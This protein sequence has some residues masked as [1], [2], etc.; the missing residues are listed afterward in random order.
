MSNPFKVFRKH[1]KK[2]IAALGVLCMVAFTILPVVMQMFD[3][4]G[5]SPSSTVVTTRY[6]E[7]SEGLLGQLLSQRRFV[8]SF[9]FQAMLPTLPDV[10]QFEVAQRDQARYFYQVMLDRDI[11]GMFGSDTEEDV[12]DGWLMSREAERMGIDFSDAAVT[13]FIR[14]QTQNRVDGATLDNLVRS[15]GGT[16]AMLY[17]ALRRELMAHAARD[18]LQ[19]SSRLTPAERWEYYRRLNAQATIEV[20]P[21]RVEDFVSQVPEPSGDVVETF[22]DEHKDDLPVPGSP[23]PGFKKPKECV[24]QFFQAALEP[25][26]DEADVTEK[27]IADHYEQFKEFRY[28]YTGFSEDSTT[29]S[30][31]TSSEETS[32]EG[33]ETSESA[34]ESPESSSSAPSDA[35]P[36]SDTPPS[37]SEPPAE[38]EGGPALQSPGEGTTEPPDEGSTSAVRSR[39][40]ELATTEDTFQFVSYLQESNEPATT[41]ESAVAD[42]TPTSDPDATATDDS[43]TGE[44]ETG[45]SP[46]AD[47][48]EANVEPSVVLPPAPPL[49]EPFEMPRD[50][51]SGPNPKYDPLWKVEDRIRTEL[52][53]ERAREE[54]DS[55]LDDLRERMRSYKS[56]RLRWQLDADDGITAP[57]PT[58]IDFDGLSAEHALTTRTTG[59]IS[60]I[61]FLQIE[62]IGDATVT[63]SS[64]GGSL[65]ARLF[66]EFPTYEPVRSE[67]VDGTR[68]L[69]WKTEEVNEHIPELADVRD[70]VVHAWKMIEAYNLALD[71][72]QA[73]VGQAGQKPGPLKD[74]IEGDAALSV[75]ESLPFTWLTTGLGGMF[76]QSS[77]P[78]LSEVKGVDEPGE[79]FMSDVFSLE[80]G[81]VGVTSNQPHTMAYVI[82]VTSLSPSRE[83]LWQSFYNDERSRETN[84]TSQAAY[85]TVALIEAE[86]AHQE[87]IEQVRSDAKVTWQRPPR[88]A[89]R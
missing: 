80:V 53:N 75:T 21:V 7:I 22:F 63:G 30:D 67:D 3:E 9:L 43:A 64:G 8:K 74:A 81:E 16:H 33:T 45:N 46:A 35:T 55:V 89:D 29:T 42:G 61:E 85:S 48:V 37:T 11:E 19:P 32:T 39:T 1:Q 34:T 2:S 88:V 40:N 36:T 60:Q 23:T 17:D 14:D 47:S 57:E 20:L 54:I 71:R 18:E 15:L 78:E 76:N 26:V 72:A 25:F 50:V 27:E 70:S 62:G 83:T 24:V 79:D 82:R 84:A 38:G 41:P 5:G 66:S 59:L 58:P 51:R 77:M 87:W 52:A 6:G 13:Q 4:P 49:P 28:L 10:S 12:V 56:L 68:Y 73:L 86:K 69:A 31:S 65:A 44:S